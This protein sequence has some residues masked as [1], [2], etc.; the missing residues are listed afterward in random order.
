M[1]AHG[2]AGSRLSATTDQQAQALRPVPGWLMPMHALMLCRTPPARCWKCVIICLIDLSGLT[3]P[4][5]DAVQD[6]A[7]QQHRTLAWQYGI[8]SD[9]DADWRHRLRQVNS[10][11][12]R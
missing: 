11:K 2:S 7:Q 8:L 5:I 3:D 4:C 1:Q 12:A 9:G 10:Y 6:R